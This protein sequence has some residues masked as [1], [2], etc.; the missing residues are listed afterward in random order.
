[1]DSSRL[2]QLEEQLRKRNEEIEERRRRV[3]SEA[4]A[5][6]RPQSS[7]AR[8]AQIEQPQYQS[9]NEADDGGR[10]D[11]D[12]DGSD[13]VLSDDS[14]EDVEPRPA[15]PLRMK[16]ASASGSATVNNPRRPYSAMN[17]S[18]LSVNTSSAS[19]SPKK[20]FDRSGTLFSPSKSAMRETTFQAARDASAGYGRQFSS[21]NYSNS[22]STRSPSNTSRSVLAPTANENGDEQHSMANA[23]DRG[24]D[25][26]G[27]DDDVR[28]GGVDGSL[29]RDSSHDN[30]SIHEGSSSSFSV[31]QGQ[32]SRSENSQ[33]SS[34]MGGSGAGS[35][36]AE[37]EEME[38][39]LSMLPSDAAL[40]FQRARVAALQEQ[41][42]DLSR[43]LTER[44][45]TVS[46]LRRNEKAMQ[47]EVARLQKQVESFKSR[48]EKME[49]RLEKEKE[50]EDKFKTLY[51]EEKKVRDKE[52]RELKKIEQDMQSV[53]VRLQ[54]ALEEVD[55]YKTLLKD[56]RSQGKDITDTSKRQIEKLTA[57]NK[58]LERQRNEVV[59]AFKK[60]LK[61]IDVLKR[62]RIHMEAARLL[63]FSEEEFAKTIELGERI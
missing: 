36:G 34:S 7:Y 13:H 2:A 57:E 45:D 5:A 46:S 35:A 43:Q 10:D 59:N 61:L 39:M 6:T 42:T 3:L 22:I 48:Q 31:N 56:V 54:R 44:D 53:Q 63:A 50:E 16:P 41:V 33:R 14:D 9:T 47:E 62:Q 49:N 58:R 30:A 18:S 15:A 11:V 55:K 60:Q 23:G 51:L 8:Y 1:M 12:D 52:S 28:S 24:H 21:N 4:A 27:G 20:S 32:Q 29:H 40:R 26:D 37:D 17:E 25:E 38:K 19:G